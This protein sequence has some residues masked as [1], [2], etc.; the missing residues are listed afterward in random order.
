MANKKIEITKA[1]PDN[2]PIAEKTEHSQ[3]W[4][5][6]EESNVHDLPIEMSDR[7]LKSMVLNIW[8]EYIRQDE[9]LSAISFLENAPYRV[10]HS[11]EIKQALY[12]TKSSTEWIEKTDL[13]EDLNSPTDLSGKILKVE[14]ANPLPHPLLGQVGNRFKWVTDRLGKEKARIID[15]GCLDGGMTNRWGM[16]GHEVIGIDLNSNSCEIANRKAKEFDTGA[17]HINCFFKDVE[18]SVP[19]NYFDIATCCDAYEHLIDPVNDLLIPARKCVRGDGKMLLVTPHGSWMRGHLLDWTFP[20]RDVQKHGTWLTK[21]PRAHLVAPTIQTVSENFKK[22]G[23]WVRY[24]EIMAQVPGDVPEQ[25]N[26]CVEALPNPPPRYPGNKIVVVGFGPGHEY[27]EDL[28]FVMN[29]KA[30]EGHSIT[31]YW[32]WASEIIFDFIHYMK[33]DDLFETKCDILYTED[34]NKTS[35]IMCGKSYSNLWDVK[36]SH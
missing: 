14:V 26:V 23:W 15:F 1:N 27:Y 20:W 2:F 25:G 8:R 3:V 5:I 10:R 36:Y 21:E 16:M 24:C 11:A 6:P 33:I 17:S 30:R 28:K 29:R 19:R 32:N 35:H 18:N 7:Q 12:L 31:W 34:E 13:V 9:I 22:A 4:G